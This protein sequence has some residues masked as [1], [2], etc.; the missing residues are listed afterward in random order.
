M[1]NTK[2]QDILN[3][4][5]NGLKQI[6]KNEIINNGENEVE[7]N[8][9]LASQRLGE[10]W[11]LLKQMKQSNELWLNLL[12]CKSIIIDLYAVYFGRRKNDGTLQKFIE[13]YFERRKQK[14]Y[15]PLSDESRNL[16]RIYKIGNKIIAH[17]MNTLL[18]KDF[19]IVDNKNGGKIVETILAKTNV[20]ASFDNVELKKQ[21]IWTA[22]V[23]ISYEYLTSNKLKEY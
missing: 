6:N 15:I 19:K 5:M 3:D 2:P 1:L 16:W 21:I 18:L 7:T 10:A 22:R 9:I 20:N 14:N 11:F 12:F 8:L 17:S 13:N 4:F 23:L